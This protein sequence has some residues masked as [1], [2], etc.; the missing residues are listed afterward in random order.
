M[1]IILAGM[2]MS[3]F[4]MVLAK[5]VR[6]LIFVFFLQ[7]LLLFAATLAVAIERQ[8]VELYLVAALVLVVKVALMPWFLNRVADRIR[9]TDNLGLII[10]PLLSMAAAAALSG[11]AYLFALEFVPA[12][13][14]VRITSFTVSLSMM[15]IGMFLMIFRMK[16]LAQVI[17]LM[18]MENGLFLAGA[19]LCGGM[20]FFI[21]IAV[22]FDVLVCVMI[23]G[24]FVYR[25]NAL[26]THIDVHKLRR[27]RG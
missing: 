13:D 1:T 5:R 22:F 14:T 8:E 26:F 17:G 10:T 15:L 3:T 18:A 6:V 4:F 25:I 12:A 19:A 27:L 23:A 21:E 7:S 11:M 9:V 20:P 16:A 2:L 24:V